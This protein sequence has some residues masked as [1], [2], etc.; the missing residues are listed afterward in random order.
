MALND[1][2]DILWK[3]FRLLLVT[4][5]LFVAIVVVVTEALPRTYKATATLFV[6][7]TKV[8][9]QATALDSSVGTS[10]THTYATLLADPTVAEE[11]RSQLPVV[12]TRTQL[13]A[14]MSFAPV[15]LT[16]LVLVSSEDRSATLAATIANAYARVFVAHVN[17]EYAAGSVPTTIALTVS[18]TTPTSPARP[19]P[20]LYI[21]LGAVLALFLAVGVVLAV[22]RVQ[23][24]I[25][26]D[27]ESTTVLGR[28]VIAHIPVIRKPN[29]M[30]AP[31]VADAFRMMRL[32]L[33][34]PAMFERPRVLVVTSAGRKEGKTLVA[35]HL[36]VTAAADGERVALIDAD[37]RRLGMTELASP[38]GGIGPGGGLTN[39]L[40][41]DVELRQLIHRDARFPDVDL[42]LA[43]PVTTSPAALLRSPR[44]TTLIDL[45][46]GEYDRVVIDTPPVLVGPDATLVLAQCDAAV[47]VVDLHKTRRRQAIA[48]LNQIAH[49]S[50]PLAGLVLNRMDSTYA[51]G[52]YRRHSESAQVAGNL[53]R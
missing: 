13:L 21:G 16:Q 30:T 23:D 7:P 39:Y 44:L 42:I 34:L 27:Q 46:R 9:S 12:M 14:T 17:S 36:A 47:C 18:A 22:E 41:G 26:P 8:V 15:E 5:V 33:D 2:W 40:L 52:S 31:E 32:N 3:R 37:L 28:P 51:Y 48:G 45:L 43:G 20:P 10:L 4:L 29:N 35:S 19:N 38:R 53:A 49:T 25:V 6:G 1:I 24:R 50:S 11:V